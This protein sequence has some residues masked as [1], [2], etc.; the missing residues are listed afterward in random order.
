VPFLLSSHLVLALVKLNTKLAYLP[1][2]AADPVGVRSYMA[3]WELGLM[4]RPGMWFPISVVKTGSLALLLLGTV[5]SLWTHSKISRREG[6][7]AL[8]MIFPL[9]L[10]A[11]VVYGGLVN[12]LF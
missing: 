9:L 7:G 4:P 5:L 11:A 3:M 12:W 2:A 6:M 10:L 8:P 1:T